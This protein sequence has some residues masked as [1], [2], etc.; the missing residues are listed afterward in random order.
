MRVLKIT[1]CKLWAVLSKHDEVGA[2][3]GF[4]AWWALKEICACGVRVESY[5]ESSSEYEYG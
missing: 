5:S 3:I 4:L 2:K 1:A